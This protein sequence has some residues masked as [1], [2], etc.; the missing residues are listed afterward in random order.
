MN[1]ITTLTIS[2]DALAKSEAW[3]SRRD[4]LL[5]MASQIHSIKSDPQSDSAGQL[6][7]LMTKHINELEKERKAVTDPLEA[8][9]KSI[10]A[11]QRELEAKLVAS[12]D[13]LK[14]ENTAYQT[15][16]AMER[17]AAQRAA[18]DAARRAAM[19]AARE[20]AEAAEV[21]GA[22]VEV[23]P[24]APVVEVYVPEADKL[25]NSK[26]VKR[27]EFAMTDSSMVPTDYLIL[28]DKAV[29]AFIKGCEAIGKDPVLPG[30][31]FSAKMSVESK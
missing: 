14:A 11:Q 20:A 15:K 19:E 13:R 23:E 4:E 9:K 31:K 18:E 28:N 17:E 3:L 6:Q 27:W 25:S 16:L 21:F 10:I 2:S 30:V 29:R 12:R 1:E 7:T 8:M 26:V 24:T 22:D 5:V